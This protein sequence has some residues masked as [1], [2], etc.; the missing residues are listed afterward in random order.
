MHPPGKEFLSKRL[1]NRWAGESLN[2][3]LILAL[4]HA[5]QEARLATEPGIAALIQMRV[6]VPVTK[7]TL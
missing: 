7:R 4:A 1:R 6:Q 5:F 3:C 2:K